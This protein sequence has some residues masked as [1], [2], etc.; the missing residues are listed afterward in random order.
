ML[1]G[2]RMPRIGQRIAQSENL[3]EKL[4]LDFC[5]RGCFLVL[6]KNTLQQHSQNDTLI[7]A[8]WTNL[9]FFMIMLGK[10][11]RSLQV[12]CRSDEVA[13]YLGKRKRPRRV[14]RLRISLTVYNYH[15][16]LVMDTSITRSCSG[17]ALSGY[18]ITSTSYQEKCKG[19]TP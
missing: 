10:E 5:S 9:Y 2:R 8:Y 6:R 3:E 12:C 7:V 14:H 17:T 4:S 16:Y 18:R 19:R 1:E 13:Y 11:S 15:S